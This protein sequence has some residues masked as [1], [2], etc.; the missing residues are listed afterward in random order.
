[1]SSHVIL[2]CSNN[3]DLRRIFIRGV[4]AGITLLMILTLIPAYVVFIMSQ[5]R[6]RLKISKVY[7]SSGLL[8]FTLCLA[9]FVVLVTGNLSDCTE[10]SVFHVTFTVSAVLNSGVQLGVVGILYQRLV[11]I[12]K[13]TA[14]RV[15]KCLVVT[16]W[17]MYVIATVVLLTAAVLF[18]VAPD[19]SGELIAFAAVL[20]ISLICWMDALFIFK[21]VKVYKNVPK[22]NGGRLLLVIT[23]N[24]ILAVVSTS[25]T[26]AVFS[27]GGLQA[28][29]NSYHVFILFAIVVAC[30]LYSNFVCIMLTFSYFNNYYM[31]M[32][33]GL[34]RWCSSTMTKR[35]MSKEDQESIRSSQAGSEA[36]ATA[37]S[38]MDSKMK[39]QETVDSASPSI[40]PSSPQQSV[41][42]AVNATSQSGDDV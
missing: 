41:E 42:L 27:L 29:T 31:K 38:G 25:F 21:L 19:L 26:F 40:G 9:T 18:T 37:T 39:S 3:E 30:D 34:D 36:P 5:M 12:F 11:D 32:C 35:V 2:D 23:K 14:M 13:D 1:M 20:V 8:F 24:C 6:G 10:W 28:T 7:F 22:R 4:T 15:G 33:G 17:I 16:F